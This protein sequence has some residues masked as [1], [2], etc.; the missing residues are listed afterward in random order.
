MGDHAEIFK[1]LNAVEQ[2]L[3]RINERM[4]WFQRFMWLLFPRGGIVGWAMAKVF[5]V[6]G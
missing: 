1:R 6:G 2:E 3:A 4:V 5:G